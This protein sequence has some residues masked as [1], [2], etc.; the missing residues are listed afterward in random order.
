M[1][2]AN[3]RQLIKFLRARAPYQIGE[4]AGFP[5]GTAKRFVNAGIAEDIGP[6]KNRKPTQEELDAKSETKK[7]RKRPKLTKEMVASA[8]DTSYVTKDGK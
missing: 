1:S 6:V 2:E 7:D 4:I 5:P 3:P 8:R